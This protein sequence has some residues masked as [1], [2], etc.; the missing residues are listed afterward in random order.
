MTRH[1]VLVSGTKAINELKGL[2][3]IAPEHPRSSLRGHPLATQLDRNEAAFAS[4]AGA[5]PLEASSGQRT[6]H[7]LSRG[8]GR[9]LNHAPHT[10]AITRMRCHP[11]TRACE[12][13]RTAEGKTH[14][15]IRRERPPSTNAGSRPDHRRPRTPDRPNYPDLRCQGTLR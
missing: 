15:D 1:A 9:A 7:R 12:I 11:E 5:A 13:R 3:V 10:V 8:G 14:R 4:L 6:R 2:I